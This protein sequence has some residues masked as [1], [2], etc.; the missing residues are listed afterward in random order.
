MAR[1]KE[2]NRTP[3]FQSLEE[4]AAFWKTHSPLDYPEQW[5]EDKTFTTANPL[6]HTL[7]VRLD[8]NTIDKLAAIAHKKGLG[9]STLARMW[10]LE[11][12]ELLT[13]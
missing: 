8:T 10:L 6:V 9:P 2:K 13:D 5:V 11:R 3:K 7:A 12:L 1:P 4:E